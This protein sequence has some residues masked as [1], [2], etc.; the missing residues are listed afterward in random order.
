MRRHTKLIAVAAAILVAATFTV[1]R[2]QQR[3][4][5]QAGTDTP[6]MMEMPGMPAMR[7]MRW[8]M[9]MMDGCPMMQAM[10]GGPEALLGHREALRLSNDQ[11]ARLTELRDAAEAGMR[12]AM[13]QLTAARKA[14]DDAADAGRL[15]EAAVR[16]AL[17]R[18]GR[19]H[20]DMAVAML[21]ARAEARAVLT[22]DQREKLER[23][24]GGMM[25]TG[26]SMMDMP[27]M[28]H[29]GMG[30]G[31]DHCP[32]TRGGMRSDSAPA[33]KHR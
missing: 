29:S 9:K 10:T 13:A 7:A 30:M 3:D 4:T 27:M 20:A 21:R 22:P 5:A 16:A 8:M 28:M 25:G 15:D 17:Q 31:M 23:G 11:V 19:A 26:H 14:L 6:R 33:R 32:M 2:A 12:D 24:A 1:S 18:M